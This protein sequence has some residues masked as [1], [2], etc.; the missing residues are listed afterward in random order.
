MVAAIGLAGNVVVMAALWLAAGAGSAFIWAG[1]NT[2]AVRSAPENRGG[3]IS[4]VGA[5]KFAGSA[6]GPL[7]WLPLYLEGVELAFA[8]AGL[9]C[10]LIAVVVTG[11]RGGPQRIVMAAAERAR[12]TAAAA[13]Q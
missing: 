9:A 4:V 5:F 8:L 2:L 7:V 3:A 10:A 13:Q 1:L 11:L 12:T 6:L